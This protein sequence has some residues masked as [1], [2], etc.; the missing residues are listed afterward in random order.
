[1]R[2]DAV[3]LRIVAIRAATRESHHIISPGPAPVRPSPARKPHHPPR[4]LAHHAENE[5]KVREMCSQARAA[6]KRTMVEWIEE[7]TSMSMLF[8]AG[9]N[10]AQGNPDWLRDARNLS[11]TSRRNLSLLPRMLNSVQKKPGKLTGK[12]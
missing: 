12:L 10:F 2:A 11:L 7:A 3:P 1:M 4:T 5:Q 6:G 9:V 8:S